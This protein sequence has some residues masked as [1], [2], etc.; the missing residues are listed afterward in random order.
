MNG[1][2]AYLWFLDFNDNDNDSETADDLESDFVSESSDDNT[3]E[4]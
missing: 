1:D 4:T 3:E 2:F